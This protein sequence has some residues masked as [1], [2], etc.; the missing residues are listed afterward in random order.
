MKAFKRFL[1]KLISIPLALLL[2]LLALLPYRVL[3]LFSHFLYFLIWNVT[4]Y[5]KKVVLGNLEKAFPEKSN[6]ERIMIARGFY[7]HLSDL[8][9]EAI[10]LMAAPASTM[11]RRVRLDDESQELMGRYYREGRSAIMTLGHYGNWEW[12]GAGFNLAHPGQ[13]VAGYRYLRNK[14]F[15][16]L[17]FHTRMRFYQMLIPSKQLARKMV[18]M[19]AANEPA[20][21]ALL[22][23]QWPP[24]DTAFWIPF[25]GRE[26]PFFTGPEKLA[27]KLGHPVLFCSMRKQKRGHYL[28][29]VQV[30]TEDPRSLPE[31]E[32]TRRY[33]GL[34]EQEIRR[35][36]QYWLWSHRRWKR[37]RA[38]VRNEK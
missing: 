36:P 10:G 22:A 15:D 11:R 18:A 20:V 25:M 33:A 5:R 19:N 12:M 1:T 28:I 17:I 16:R 35:E 3:Y 14:L 7:H 37:E 2:V 9:M 4:G 38:E 24:P 8:L 31:Q 27:K 26:T 29:N 6:E 13:L 34:L 23:D 21:F 32:I 30:I